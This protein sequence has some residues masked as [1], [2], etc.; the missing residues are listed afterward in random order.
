[1]KWCFERTFHLQI[2]QMKLVISPCLGIE[3]KGIAKWIGIIL[4]RVNGK[5]GYMQKGWIYGIAICISAHSG[6]LA[7]GFNLVSS[8]F[9]FSVHEFEEKYHSAAAT[10]LNCRKF[11]WEMAWVAGRARSNDITSYQTPSFTFSSS[12]FI[13]L[14]F[15]QKQVSKIHWGLLFRRHWS[16]KW[17]CEGPYCSI[18]RFILNWKP[19]LVWALSGSQR[20]L[21]SYTKWA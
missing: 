14:P 15:S 4:A 11:G 7:V 20:P 8:Q 5:I 13:H 2:W 21:S 12:R 19:S 18:R 6:N 10:L 17:N 9:S 16:L 3:I 1:M